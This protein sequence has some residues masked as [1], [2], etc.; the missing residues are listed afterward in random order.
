M[1]DNNSPFGFQKPKDHGYLEYHNQNA[2][3]EYPAYPKSGFRPSL[4]VKKR[5]HTIL[6][7]HICVLIIIVLLTI[8]VVIALVG[9]IGIYNSKKV[10]VMWET[11][12]AVHSMTQ[13]GGSLLTDIRTAWDAANGTMLFE[14]LLAADEYADDGSVIPYDDSYSRDHHSQSD[15]K[16]DK[17]KSDMADGIHN[18]LGV[19]GDMRRSKIFLQLAIMSYRINQILKKPEAE[20]AVR[21]FLVKSAEV[22]NNLDPV[23]TARIMEGMDVGP[24]LKQA[25]LAFAQV[26]LRVFGVG[27]HH[28]HH[29]GGESTSA[30]N[31]H[32]DVEPGG[33]EEEEGNSKEKKQV[34]IE[35]LINVMEKMA[36]IGATPQ[37]GVLLENISQL[38]LQK[39]IDQGE[40]SLNET[41]S[42]IADLRRRHIVERIDNMAIMTEEILGTF[43]D[44]GI[45]ITL[46]PSGEKEIS[47]SSLPTAPML[48]RENKRQRNVK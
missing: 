43:E 39:L 12:V 36:M 8:L 13:E 44:Q 46:R 45:T 38:K 25:L 1:N 42:I 23:K 35:R 18:V 26:S 15:E 20:R 48:T 6:A 11:V 5:D 9:S 2:D 17:K 4:P 7:G 10:H 30:P 28:K 22:M 16:P 19:A 14:R 3:V 41:T 21:S 37:V 27:E 40:H 31:A 34:I 24:E 33:K 32:K 47:P 29:D